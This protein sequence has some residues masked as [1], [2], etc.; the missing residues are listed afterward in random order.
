MLAL[1]SEVTGFT[2]FYWY[3]KQKQTRFK[4]AL[5]S[6]GQPP[7]KNATVLVDAQAHG[8]TV[9]RLAA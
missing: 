5:P 6:I 2:Q 7:R 4:S 9:A 3:F 1:E 8:R